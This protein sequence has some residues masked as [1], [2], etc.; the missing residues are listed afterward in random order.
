MPVGVGG[1]PGPAEYLV[2]ESVL[3]SHGEFLCQRIKHYL[4]KHPQP[5]LG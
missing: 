1:A 4:D 5:Y 2:H 3:R